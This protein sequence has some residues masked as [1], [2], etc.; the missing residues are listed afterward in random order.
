M[1]NTVNNAESYVFKEER[2]REN[3]DLMFKN[4][5]VFIDTCSLLH[6]KFGYFLVNSMTYLIRYNT[7]L[8]IPYKCVEE[9]IKKSEDLSNP[10]LAQKAKTALTNIID[11]GKY[12]EVRGKSSDS[13][14][15][16]TILQNLLRYKE[17]FNL[18][19]IT[20]DHELAKD[21]LALNN[22]GSV[23]SFGHSII[24]KKINKYGYLTFVSSNVN[25]NK[26]ATVVNTPFYISD[27]MYNGDFTYDVVTEK[28]NE[29]SIL[30]VTEGSNRVPIKLGALVGEGGEGSVYDVV[31]SNG[32]T[33]P[34]VVKVFNSCEQSN[35]KQF[36]C[37][38]KVQLLVNCNLKNSSVCFP[39]VEVCNNMGNVIGYIMPK[40]QGVTLH[41]LL[42]SSKISV[43]KYFP[44]ATKK[45]MVQLC[46]SIINTVK[47]L[48]ERNIIIGDLQ[49]DNI[50][51]ESPTKITIIDTDSFQ[52]NEFICPVG[53]VA[54]TPPERQNQA[55]GTY[56][57]N[58]SDDLFALATIIFIIMI[59]GKFPYD[60]RDGEG[61]QQDIINGDFPYACGENSNGLAP[62][63]NWRFCW[64]HLPKELKEA[65]YNTFRKNEKYNSAEN[66][67]TANEWL[68]IFQ[69]Y[70]RRIENGNI[71][72][73]DPM[74]LDL[75]PVRLKYQKGVEYARCKECQIEYKKM[76]LDNGK[77][78]CP[79]CLD[80]G[81]EYECEECGTPMI[82][83]RR[84]QFK[85]IKKHHTCPACHEK[86]KQPYE[87][88][89]CPIDNKRFAISIGEYKMYS[90][91][92]L[93]LPLRCPECRANGR[94]VTRKTIKVTPISQVS[95][96]TRSV[97]TSPTNSTSKN[98]MQSKYQES[99]F[100]KIKRLFG[101]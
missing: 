78:Y 87:Y 92:G 97:N 94:K 28:Y 31:I 63:G 22:T 5:R 51:V 4:T 52:L 34:A 75:I 29:G 48:H 88:R 58:F 45:E 91:N 30:Y 69:R 36:Y 17:N 11:L 66:R 95:A 10:L 68:G 3:L 35:K 24:V 42:M 81:E 60:M 8:Y 37:R 73:I 23:N 47:Y 25:V 40:V 9:L 61:V 85:G 14:A 65:L 62:M 100:D 13:F 41:K 98:P 21:A 27:I 74:S 44:N 12:A 64:S 77:G 53:K 79:R 82:Y 99:F 59:P 72:T 7:K 33:V 15:D 55:Y 71:A 49:W 93:E 86:D 56:M 89:I 76:I 54:F 6:D 46:I 38:K 26:K 80:N 90:S 83:T 67:L 70:L 18:T 16:S 96:S 101:G 39:E 19:L 2:S 50:I 43:K 84:E 1:I 57:K 20:Q 32:Y